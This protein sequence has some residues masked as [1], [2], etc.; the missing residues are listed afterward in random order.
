MYESIMW[1]KRGDLA[2]KIIAEREGRSGRKSGRWKGR[3]G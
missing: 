3:E 2:Y 1:K